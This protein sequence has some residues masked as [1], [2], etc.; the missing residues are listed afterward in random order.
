M[1]KAKDHNRSTYFCIGVRAQVLGDGSARRCPTTDSPT[2]TSQGKSWRISMMKK[3]MTENAFANLDRNV[4]MR[5]V[6][7]EA[8]PQEGCYLWY[9]LKDSTTTGKSKISKTHQFL[10][11]RTSDNIADVWKR[12][13][14]KKNNKTYKKDDSFSRHFPPT[15]IVS[16]QVRTKMKGIWMSIFFGRG[17]GSNVWKKHV[18]EITG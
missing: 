14:T 8:T 11:K 18:Q 3:E 9:E 12:V 1:Q 5:S 16:N 10:N 2:Q 6:C 17:R 13:K 4:R 15:V 7:T